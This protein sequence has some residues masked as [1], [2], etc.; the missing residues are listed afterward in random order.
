MQT[1]KYTKNFTAFWVSIGGG[2]GPETWSLLLKV[3]ENV[4][5]DNRRLEEAEQ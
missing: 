5:Q 3:F 2:G 4:L 1:L